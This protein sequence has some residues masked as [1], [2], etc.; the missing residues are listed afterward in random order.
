MFDKIHYYYFNANY[1]KCLN[2]SEQFLKESP[3]F[4]LEF[5]TL[6]SYKLSLF[7]KALY[8][9]QELFSLNPTSFN[10][11]ML[12]KSYIENLRLDEALNLLQTLL[13]RK[14]DLEDELK[15]ELAFVYK[16]SNKLEESEK[17]FKE[18]L[19]KDMY[20]L[21]LWKN[22]A[23]I[24][25]KHDFTKALNAHE[26]LC[27][28]MQDLIDKLQKGII[29]EQT[30]L[31][32]V[33]LEDRLH[34]KTKENLTISKIEDFLTHQILPQKAYLLF[35]LFRISDSLELFQSLQE[36]NQHHAQFWQNYAKVLEFNSNYQE[37]YHAYKKCLSL[38][39]HA[40]YQFDL[41]YLLMRMGVDD[42]FEEGKKYYESRLFYAHNETFSTYHYNESIKAFNK[43]G[44]DAF[45][46]KEVLVFCEQGFGDTIMYTRCLEK[47]CKIAS[48]VLFAP[49]S[50]MY[51][52]F[53]NQIKFLNQ[54]DDIFKNVKV[55]KNLPTNFDYAI[56]IC[57]LPFFIDIKLSEI[58]QLKTPI[59][60]QK[61]PQNKKKK[62][63]IFY[64][65]PNAEGSDLLRNFKF[66]LLFDILKDLDYEII[67]FQM[68]ESKSLPK[69]IEDRS[70]VIKNWNDTFNNLSDI[71][72]MIS[73]DSAI[74]HLTLAMD[75]PTVVLLHP[76]FDWR[77][78][79]FEN[80][81]S[82]FWPKAKCFIIKE[83]EETKKNLQKLIKDILN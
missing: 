34:S 67:S 78:G 6:S 25:F 54:N 13:T 20:N 23:E 58:K 82:Y 72:C 16:L 28:F 35:K 21:N 14:D 53:K 4:A 46:N 12:A 1:E 43:F 71:D 5:A 69:I 41:A 75:I 7:Q 3:K 30:N 77:W 47:L 26:H 70:K 76:R 80:P 74:A 57:S 39:S 44:I 55:L 9:A 63:G 83:Q 29:A 18:L 61:K 15:L 10:G 48:K 11:L 81:K 36:A 45:K 32:L 40:T 62:L 24:Y 73:I 38:D 19:S 17:I 31:N 56:P 79:K 59:L 27:H 2:L 42:N 22:Y 60:A 50:A 68:Q 52:M 65:T 49:Q 33:K 66:E 51:E 8:Y 64:F 37:A